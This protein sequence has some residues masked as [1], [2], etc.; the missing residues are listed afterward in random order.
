[1]REP[2]LS[3][4]GLRIAHGAVEVVHGIDLDVRAGAVT[5]LLGANG[6]GK[7]TT[8]RAL[9]GH[10]RPSAGTVRLGDREIAGARAHRVARAGVALVPEGRRV[11]A[12]LSVADNLRMGGYG[13]AAAGGGP[14]ASLRR[15]RAPEAIA[16]PLALFPELEP[17]LERPAGLL[18]GGEQQMLAMGRALMRRP[19]LLVL[20]E[21][22]MGLAPKVVRRI[23][24]ALAELRARGTTI[25]LAEQN[26]RVALALADDALLLRTGV[27]AAA[28][29][30]GELRDGELV[31]DI[32]LGAG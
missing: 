26:A 11:F 6:A 4:R 25:L 30:A 22:S 14:L 3:A 7:T 23:Y 5:A 19:R 29:S 24:A 28:G 17:L 15:W 32:Y 13:A 21:P 10:L 9:L 2:L 18:S 20:D 1:M 12:S 16:E 27:V 31:R 8:L